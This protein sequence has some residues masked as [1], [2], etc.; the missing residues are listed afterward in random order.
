MPTFVFSF[1]VLLYIRNKFKILFPGR[2]RILRQQKSLMWETKNIAR[3]LSRKFL[4]FVRS[5]WRKY[6]FKVLK[7]IWTVILSLY[8]FQSPNRFL[9]WILVMT[10]FT[11]SSS[12]LF[13]TLWDPY[14]TS[15]PLAKVLATMG[16]APQ[17]EA[18]LTVSKQGRHHNNHAQHDAHPLIKRNCFSTVWHLG[19]LEKNRYGRFALSQQ[20]SSSLILHSLARGFEAMKILDCP[21]D[22]ICEPL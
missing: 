4:L 15:H 5:W 8:Q 9:F 1:Q 19:G 6:V 20:T 14:C 17:N 13:A 3:K 21:N 7:K 22:N 2:K 12:G 10:L 16:W 11:C 18:T